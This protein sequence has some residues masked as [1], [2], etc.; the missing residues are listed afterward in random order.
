MATLQQLEEGIKRAYYAGNM[1]Y[2]R[3]LGAVL[4]K[5]RKDTTNQTPQQ[6]RRLHLHR[7]GFQSK[8]ANSMQFRNY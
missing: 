2:A 7:L 4:V 5:A 1:E 3:T 8:G 6:R